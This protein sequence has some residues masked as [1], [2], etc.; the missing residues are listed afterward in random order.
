MAT[1]NDLEQAAGTRRGSRGGSD[2]DVGSS[3]PFLVLAGE[4]E[5]LRGPAGGPTRILARAE[6]TNGGFTALENVIAPNRDRSSTSTSA[7]TRC[8]TSSRARSASR[9]A[10]ATSMPRRVRSCSYPEALATASRTSATMPH[11]CDVRAGG[12]GALLRGSSRDAPGPAGP[13]DVP[14]G[15]ARGMDGGRRSADGAGGKV[16]PGSDRLTSR[17]TSW[18]RRRKTYRGRCQ[19]PRAFLPVHGSDS[20]PPPCV[21]RNSQMTLV[22]SRCGSFDR[23]ARVA[24]TGGCWATCGRLRGTA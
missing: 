4:G 5:V 24:G 10:G 17:T 18:V 3:E 16:E 23:R 11:P 6:T 12:D 20:R 2:R 21:A 19:R 9:P 7:K 22:A 13:R 8:T 14:A 15:R 1:S